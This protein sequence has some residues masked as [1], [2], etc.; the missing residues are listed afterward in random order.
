MAWNDILKPLSGWKFLFKKPHTIRYPKEDKIPS[1]RYRGIHTNMIDKCIGCGSCEK[2]CMNQAITMKE[3]DVEVKEGT[4][5]LRPVVDHGRC[6]Y[7]GLCVDIC[8]TGS[9]WLSR[10]YRHL[11]EDI[12]TFII[13]PNVKEKE[14]EGWQKAPE[15]SLIPP[16]RGKMEEIPPEKRVKSFMEVFVGYTEPIA[17]EEAQRCLGCG[18]CVDAC[19]THMHIPDYLKAIREGNNEEAVRIMF[20]NNPLS[21]ICGTV[22][23]HFCENV[24][25][26]GIIGEPV[27]IQW[28]KEFATRTIED[29]KKII[30][31]TIKEKKERV[32]VVGAGPAGLSFA[33]YLRLK[34]YKI[35]VFEKYEK[36]GGMMLL[37]I[38]SYRLP[39]KVIEKEIK[40]ITSTGVKIHTGTQIGKKK[41]FKEL[42]KKYS[43]VFV[44]TGNTKPYTMGIPGEEGKDTLQAISFLYD[45]NTGKKIDLKGKKVLVV[46]GGN[47]AMDAIRTSRRLGADVYLSY[48]RREVDMPADELERKEA[49]EEGIEF[50][51]QTLPIEVIREKGKIKAV[52]YVPTD[53]D[54]SEKGKRPKP[55]PRMNDVRTLEVDIIIEAIGQGPD[56]TYLEQ[57]FGESLKIEKGK[58]V[59]DKNLMCSIKGLFFGGDMANKQNDIVSAVADGRRAAE[60][61]HNYLQNK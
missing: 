57:E 48:R 49:K 27:A 60:G 9:L 58:P 24:C 10:D 44:A 30:D 32:A 1:E 6:C 51:I 40:F 37:G 35:D 5:N 46:G 53:M 22:C 34:G 14:R 56:L 15:F 33:F 20:K 61:V 4:T 42:L 11:S 52:K 41:T 50:M 28:E 29:Y 8:P 31:T 55:V 3:M 59:V 17:K 16:E 43:A 19:A 2:I 39:R 45:V 7:C 26:V 13:D 21:E 47:V 23:T 36:P 38:P 54:F 18:L 12:D 25:P